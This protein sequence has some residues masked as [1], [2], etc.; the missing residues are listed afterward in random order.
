[1][2]GQDKP[3]GAARPQPETLAEF[4]AAARNGG[5]KPDDIGTTATP[6]TAPR[7]DDPSRKDRTATEV[8]RAGV[9]KDPAA[10]TRAAQARRDP[11]IAK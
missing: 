10:A 6:E 1:M 4:D 3:S 7:P 8:L 2:T 5:V 9:E 11:R